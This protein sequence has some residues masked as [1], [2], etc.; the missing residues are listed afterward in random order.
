MGG[1]MAEGGHRALEAWLVA[2]RNTVPVV[3]RLAQDVR[4]AARSVPMELLEPHR[5][6]PSG[7]PLEQVSCLPWR[8]G[9]PMTSAGSLS[10][11]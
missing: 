6:V 2:H 5:V 3:R 7:G 9:S 4:P 10:L 1:E 8:L 11:S